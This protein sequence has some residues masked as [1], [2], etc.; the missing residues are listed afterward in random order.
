MKLQWPPKLE[1]LSIAVKELIPV[2][3][4]AVIFGSQ[5]TGKVSQFKVDNAAVVHIIGAT[6]TQNSHIMH[7]VGLLVFCAS[8][9][10][11]FWFKVSHIPGVANT[12]ADALLRN[13]IDEF[14]SQVPY[15]C[16]GFHRSVSSVGLP[17]PNMDI[18]SLDGTLQSYYSTALAKLAQK[19][20][21]PFV[22]KV[23][24]I[25]K[26]KIVHGI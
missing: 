7:L 24:I 15:A 14:F 26:Y 17:Q 13:N 21:M 3:L 8:Y 9:L 5:W 25:K 2:V 6:Y 18:H 12:A 10:Y 20:E 1:D 16:Q 22:P 11:N 19:Y 23:C 4:A